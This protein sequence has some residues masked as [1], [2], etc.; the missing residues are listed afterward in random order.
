MIVQVCLV[1][2]EKKLI[3]H[4]PRSKVSRKEADTTVG[5]STRVKFMGHHMHPCEF[6]IAHKRAT[7]QLRGKPCADMKGYE[8]RRPPKVHPLLPS[9]VAACMRARV[10]VTAPP[11]KAK[12]TPEAVGKEQRGT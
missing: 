11:N 10:G 6:R 7:M 8:W 4:L 5:S 9:R 2:D 12:K 3:Y 1:F